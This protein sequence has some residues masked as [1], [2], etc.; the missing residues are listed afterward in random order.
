M[1][2]LADIVAFNAAHPERAARFGQD[3]FLAAAATRGDL[4]ELEYKSARAMDMRS[5]ATLGLD[6]YMDAHRLDAVLFP[7][8]AGAEDAAK[9][10][11]PSVQ[12]PAGLTAGNR[13]RRDPRLPDRRDFHRPRLERGDAAAHRLCLRAGLAGAAPTSRISDAVKFYQ[14]FRVNAPRDCHD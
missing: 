8:A 12:V 9:P 13:R 1:R 4:A 11:Y 6:A 3:L 10:G 14:H 2:S 5:A 7:G